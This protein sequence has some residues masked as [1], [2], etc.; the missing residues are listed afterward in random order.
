MAEKIEVGYKPVAGIPG[1]Y[2]K[3][4]VYTNSAGEQSYVGIYPQN[5]TFSDYVGAGASFGKIDYR[6]GVYDSSSRDW[7]PARA[8]STDPTYDPNATPHP[9]ETIKEGDGL[10]P[11]FERARDTVADIYTRGIDYGPKDTNS[12]AG[13]DEALRGAGLPPTTEDGPSDNWSPGSD[14]DLPGGD[15]APGGKSFGEELGDWI[16]DKLGL[17]DLSDALSD[18]FDRASRWRP[19]GGDPLALDLDGDGI[20]TISADQGVLFDHDG[21]GTKHGSGWLNSDDGLL[22]LDKNGNGFIDNGSELF[23]VDTVKANGSKAS[24]GF[25]ALRDLDANRDGLFDINDADYANVRVWR[26]LNQDGISQATELKTLADTGITSINL[27]ATVNSTNLWNGNRLT[28]TGTYTKTD[29]STGTAANLVPDANP[30]FREFGDSIPLTEEAR[31]Q[32]NMR[33]SGAVRDLREAVSVS[34]TLVGQLSSLSGMSRSEMLAA[35]DGVIASWAATSSMQT[36]V[37]RAAA[38]DAVLYYVVPG[39]IGVGSTPAGIKRDLVDG[40]RAAKISFSL[41]GFDVSNWDAAWALHDRVTHIVGVLEKFNGATFLNFNGVKVFS[42]VGVNYAPEFVEKPAVGGVVPSDYDPYI[43]APMLAPQIALLEQSYAALKESVYGALVTQTRLKPYLEAINLT[44]TGTGEIALDFSGIQTRYEAHKA[45]DP[46]NALIDLIELQRY[47][48]S[49][50]VGMGFNI[51]EIALADMTAWRNDVEIK[52]LLNAANVRFDDSTNGYMGG[53]YYTNDTLIE[54]EAGSTLSASGGNDTLFGRT[55]ADNLN[56]GLGD[57]RLY[58]GAGNDRLYGG[59][60][61]DMDWKRV[62]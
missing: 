3:Y 1:I 37:E 40:G 62:A 46:R 18:F 29:G 56:G 49:A 32:P 30:F 24:D 35:L 4:I 33:G 52:A 9:R 59:A 61:N 42:G 31:A 15:V 43:F 5:Y 16:R 25:D 48:G 21:D 13:I 11:D 10:L 47:S 51:G 19:R 50:L 17:D 45:T 44:L 27:A 38:I 8:P 58:G 14:F 36:S 23:G 2:H 41:S 12:N 20:E 22:V 60:G 26:D 57:D 55:G 53:G 34:G 28:H 54:R 39:Q 7:D 6:T